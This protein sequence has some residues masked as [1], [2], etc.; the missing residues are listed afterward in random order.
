MSQYE[1]EGPPPHNHRVHASDSDDDEENEAFLSFSA[2]SAPGAITTDNIVLNATFHSQ[3]DRNSY[4]QAASTNSEISALDDSLPEYPRSSASFTRHNRKDK[5]PMSTLSSSSSSSSGSTVTPTTATA[6]SNSGTTA[7]SSNS[8][9]SNNKWSTIGHQI[10]F[11]GTGIFSTIAVQW[12][13][14]QGAA[15]K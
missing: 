9:P 6:E 3:H 1:R 10:S 11:L 8:K 2:P 5:Y 15:C 13:Y 4:G 12:L 14:Y 7:S